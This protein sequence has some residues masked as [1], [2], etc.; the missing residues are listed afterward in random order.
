MIIHPH[1]VF[2]GKSYHFNRFFGILQ[3]KKCSEQ[4]TFFIRD[5]KKT[6]NVDA[7]LN[8]YD[9]IHIEGEVSE[10]YSR[11]VIFYARLLVWLS[12]NCYILA[13]IIANL[14][15]NVFD[16]A[17]I[18]NDAFYKCIKGNQRELCLP[19]ALFISSTSKQFKSN[20][21]MFIGVY[22]PTHNMHAWVMENGACADNYDTLW[23]DY[24][25]ILIVE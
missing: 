18:A 24:T 13:I 10:S 4:N 11:W 14:R 6:N 1:L 22:L 7:I 19:R 8:P 21:S 12:A 9:V 2:K 5:C 23:I 17:Q 20:G 15:L 16:T 25:P 3:S